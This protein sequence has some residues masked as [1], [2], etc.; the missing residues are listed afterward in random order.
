MAVQDA[1]VDLLLSIFARKNFPEAARVLRPTGWLALVYPGV[2]HMVELRDRFGLMRRHEPAGRRYTEAVKRFVGLP[3]ID[4]LRRRIVMDD[5][6]IRSAIL[7]GPQLLTGLV[8]FGVHPHFRCRLGA[9]RACLGSGIC[10][11]AA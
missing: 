1:A 11:H 8:R 10:D 9:I 5:V 6:A 4:R 3:I 2:D 7:M